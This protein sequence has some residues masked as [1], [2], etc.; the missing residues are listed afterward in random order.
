MV[1]VNG[2][3]LLAN[4]VPPTT[5]V[6]A[7]PLNVAET[8]EAAKTRAAPISSAAASAISASDVSR[9][10]RL[11]APTACLLAQSSRFGGAIV[12]GLVS[13]VRGPSYL[14]LMAN[15]CARPRTG[16]VGSPGPR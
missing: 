15:Q 7:P 12:G 5:A 9:R 4:R 2:A 8:T 10:D 1:S 3:S 11:V 13:L 6:P 16:G 14:G